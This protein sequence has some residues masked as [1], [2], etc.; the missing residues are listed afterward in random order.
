M[1]SLD[2]TE[3]TIE[4]VNPRTGKV[5]YSFAPPQADAIAALC[6]RLRKAQVAWGGAPLSQRVSVLRRWADVIVAHADAITAAEIADT[7]R[8]RVATEVP[9]MVA[10]SIR[11][12][13]DKAPAIF[14]AALLEGESTS[15]PGIRYRTH[16]SAY[17][18]LGVVSPWNHPFLLSMIDAIPAMLAGCAVI[19]K[20]SEITPRFVDPVRA[21]IAE[22]PELAAVL[23]YVQGDGTTG[24]AIIKQVDALCFTGGVPTGRKIAITCAQRF[25]PCFLELGGKDAAIVTEDADIDCAASAVLK[26]AVHNT[27]QLCFSTERVY[28]AEAVAEPFVAALV[29]KANALELNWPDIGKGH[30]GPFIM[31]RQ[32]DI[33]DAHIDDA[34]AKG[35]VL[36]SG[37]KSEVHDGGRYMRATVLTN[38][39]HSMRIMTEETFGPVVPVMT[40]QDED[41][42]LALANDSIFGLSGAVIAGDETKAAAIA[43]RMNAGGISLQDCSLTLG[44]LRDAEKVSFGQSGLG[45]SRMG[46]NAITRFLRKKALMVRPGVPID[47]QALGEAAPAGAH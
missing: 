30:L 8:R 18:L 38:V 11:G 15:V 5:D 47:M 6:A 26:G 1:I 24:Q 45:G 33:V 44:I 35:A 21:T 37:G 12:W 29:D 20:P 42:A 27:G 36:R 17:P 23:A 40:Y 2:V 32:A 46:P 3:R 13:C 14:A 28:V 7:G 10:A 43:E 16:L 41:E 39:D 9:R 4:A 22:V 31:A 34:L 19:V 25:I